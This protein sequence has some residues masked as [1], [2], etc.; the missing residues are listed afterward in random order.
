[1]HCDIRSHTCLSDWLH[2][3]ALS[4]LQSGQQLSSG[5]LLSPPVVSL[6][7]CQH[8]WAL[9][10]VISC[11]IHSKPPIDRLTAGLAYYRCTR[12]HHDSSMAVPPLT[13]SASWLGMWP[14]RR[15]SS[16]CATSSSVA[17]LAMAACT[18]ICQPQIYVHAHCRHSCMQTC[19]FAPLPLGH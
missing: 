4:P 7:G 12:R 15:A 17:A 3:A 13:A 18:S 10:P 9:S 16:S 8:A 1:M 6:C 2:V 19:S 5:P 11:L 14:V